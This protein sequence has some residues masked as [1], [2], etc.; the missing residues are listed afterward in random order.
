MA[1]NLRTEIAQTRPF[2][3]RQQEAHLSIMRTAAALD[4]AV[5]E[6]LKPYG[7]TP[8]QY[9][10]L[11]ILRGAGDEGLC[12]N[13]VRDRMV[14]KVPDTTRMLDRME[15][16]GLVER[17]RDENDRRFVTTR[18]SDEGLRLTAELDE[19]MEALAHKH[20]GHLTKSELTMLIDLLA[21]IREVL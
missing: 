14:A 18:I 19:P 2:A 11:R 13:A 5:S 12:R 8:A 4:H 9:N 6:A 3:S 17:S 10:I 7:V 20:A 21:R 16:A 1:K 15:A